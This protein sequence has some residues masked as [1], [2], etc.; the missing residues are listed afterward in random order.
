MKRLGITRRAAGFYAV[1][2]A[3]IAV[4]G[5]FAY[6]TIYDTTSSA[7]SGVARTVTV[8]SGTVAS[9]VSASGNISPAETSS[10]TFSTSGTLTSLN[11]AVGQ[12]VKKGQV[13]GRISTTDAQSTL[14][15]ANATLQKDLAALATAKAGGTPSQI[16]QNNA[17]LSSARLQLTSAE[18]TLA[19]DQTTLA[20]ARSAARRR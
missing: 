11:A 10:P 5:W 8:S 6:S 4:A 7:S 17:S 1:L 14:S 15:T 3:A 18:Q 19:S 13:L 16:A 12:Q 20:T 9:S 2:I